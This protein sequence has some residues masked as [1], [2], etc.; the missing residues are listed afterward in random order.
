MRAMVDKTF[1][2]A[3]SLTNEQMALLTFVDNR[4]GGDLGVVIRQVVAKGI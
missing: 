2:S 4:L 3:V 1:L